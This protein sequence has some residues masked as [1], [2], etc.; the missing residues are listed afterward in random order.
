[1]GTD[2]KWGVRG[3]FGVCQKPLH[4]SPPQAGALVGSLRAR[5]RPFPYSLAPV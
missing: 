1:M 4:L 3:S 5:A 2:G